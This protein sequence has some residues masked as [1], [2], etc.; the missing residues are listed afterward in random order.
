[1]NK[2]Y[3]PLGAALACV[4]VSL[5]FYADLPEQMAVHFNTSDQPDSYFGKLYGAFF[6]P[7]LILVL[8]LLMQWRIRN[9]RDA[10]R[11]QRLLATQTSS[12]S[13]LIA[14][15][16]ALHFFTL[17]YNLGYPITPS[18]FAALVFGI[19]FIALGNLLP[20]MP[21][22]RMRFIQLPDRAYAVYARWQ[23][24]V[25]VATGVLMLFSTVLTMTVRIPYVLTVLGMFMVYTIGS[26]IY[27]SSRQ[28][29]D[30]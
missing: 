5:Y 24:R 27:Y 9:E 13:L 22:N 25:M 15:L 23:G 10:N 7:A 29:Q 3:L 21:Q 19:L 11:R 8:H 20:R 1:M 4:L 6:A 12:N 2:W 18:L 17:A 16:T 30:S 14:V 28:E 26:L